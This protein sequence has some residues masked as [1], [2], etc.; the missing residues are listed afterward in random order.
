LDTIPKFL[1]NI[2]IINNNLVIKTKLGNLNIIINFILKHNLL[3]YTF[4]NDFF[5]I[6]TINVNNIRFNQLIFLSS[7]LYNT[8]IIISS[9]SNSERELSDS[10]ITKLFK[11]TNWLERELW[12]MSGISQRNNPDLRRILTDYG[13]GGFPL[14]KDFPITGFYE[15]RYNEVYRQLIEY[16]IPSMQEFRQYTSSNPWAIEIQLII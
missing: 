5:N 11:S 16:D 6:D 15:I 7:P 12:D 3:R 1:S 9:D 14:R 8:R 13:F 2:N 4:L 10:T